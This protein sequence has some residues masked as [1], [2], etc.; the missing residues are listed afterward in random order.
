MELSGVGG[1]DEAIHNKSTLSCTKDASKFH[2]DHPVIEENVDGEAINKAI[3]ESIVSQ[4][5]R[6][7]KIHDFCLKIPIC[8]CKHC[9]TSL[10]CHSSIE[11]F[12]YR[13][14]AGC[15]GTL[16]GFIFSRNPATLSTGVF[17]GGGFFGP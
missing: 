15:S 8:L 2:S 16:V 12:F 3:Q 9:I 5:K 17:F 6:A 7:A 4:L 13:R 14:R 10:L 11:W 1:E